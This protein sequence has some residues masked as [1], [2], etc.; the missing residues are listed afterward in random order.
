MLRCQLCELMMTQS[1]NEMK[2]NVTL[3]ARVGAGP[4]TGLCYVLESVFQ[5]LPDGLATSRYGET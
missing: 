5:V 3:V 1:G 4:N 2:S